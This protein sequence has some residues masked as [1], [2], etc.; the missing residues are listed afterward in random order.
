MQAVGPA[1]ADGR[2]NADAA[3]SQ[4]MV[5]DLA[6]RAVALISSQ[7]LLQRPTLTFGNTT[8]PGYRFPSDLVFLVVPG[9]RYR[10]SSGPPA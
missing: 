2:F 7:L 1:S 8:G 10:I 9:W 5:L 4:V 6:N 3:S